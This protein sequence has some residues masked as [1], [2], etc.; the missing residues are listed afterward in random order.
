[1]GEGG[2]PGGR[3]G[4]GKRGLQGPWEQGGL[5]LGAGSRCPHPEPTSD[6]L[7]DLD[8]SGP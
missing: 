6:R 4:A 7:P 3:L 8:L 5:L 2:G 1:M